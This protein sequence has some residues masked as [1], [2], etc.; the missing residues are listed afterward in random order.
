M[1]QKLYLGKSNV[2]R[3]IKHMYVGVN[4]SLPIYDY[5]NKTVNA[6]IN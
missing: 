6:Q 2:A 4:G 5:Q 3:E 1:S